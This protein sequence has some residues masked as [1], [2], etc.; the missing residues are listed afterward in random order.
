MTIV[1]KSELNISTCTMHLT[2]VTTVEVFLKQVLKIAMHALPEWTLQCISMGIINPMHTCA[3]GGQVIICC[4]CVSQSNVTD[5][6]L[7]AAGSVKCATPLCEH[8]MSWSRKAVDG[9]GCCCWIGCFCQQ[10]LPTREAFCCQNSIIVNTGKTH[11]H[12]NTSNGDG[13]NGIVHSAAGVVCGPNTS[14][15]DGPNGIVHSTAGVASPN[16]SNGDGPNGIVHRKGVGREGRRDDAYG[17]IIHL[18][19]SL[20]FVKYLVETVARERGVARSL[21][22]G[23]VI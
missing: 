16:T 18:L 6:A 1:L 9:R 19:L 14:N 21:M 11:L 3:S 8:L 23:C 17:M 15:G 13:P 10:I 7:Y 2:S 22:G 12:H 5:R 4:L 20:C